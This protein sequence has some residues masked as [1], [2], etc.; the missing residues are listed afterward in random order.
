MAVVLKKPKGIYCPRCFS[1]EYEVVTRT[2][3][4]PGL[5]RRYYCCKDCG[6]R[7]SADERLRGVTK[8]PW[9][10]KRRGGSDTAT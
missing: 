7:F 1:D 3:P 10:G 4:M 2:Y 9:N 6:E 8:K 5:R